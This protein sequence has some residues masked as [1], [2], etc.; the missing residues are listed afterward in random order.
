MAKARRGRGEGSIHERKDGSWTAQ[1]SL[2]YDANGKRIRETLYGNTKKEVQEKLLALQQDALK[3]L[4]VKPE[5]MT[6]AQHFEASRQEGERQG[7][8]PC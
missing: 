4:P 8:H 2:G 3:G 1:V 7:V 5:R 6:V